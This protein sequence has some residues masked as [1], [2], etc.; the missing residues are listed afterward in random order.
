MNTEEMKPQVKSIKTIGAREPIY[1]SGPSKGAR[2][3]GGRPCI[4]R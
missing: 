4:A 2:E 1:M 3:L